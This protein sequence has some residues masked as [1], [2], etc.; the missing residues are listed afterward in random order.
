MHAG[1]LRRACGILA[2]DARR[3]ASPNDSN[4]GEARRAVAR[5]EARRVAARGEARREG[6]IARLRRADGDGGVGYCP[7]PMSGQET[8]SKYKDTV[9]LPDTPFPM[10]GDLATREPQIL[11]RWEETR[12]YERICAARAN[13]PLFILHDGPPYSHGNIH[14]GHRSEEHTS[15]LQ[16]RGE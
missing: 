2:R 12:L 3:C 9:V 5:G 8:K 13:A 16:S 1:G 7:L 14:Y 10:R 15:D 11:A 6:E 4:R